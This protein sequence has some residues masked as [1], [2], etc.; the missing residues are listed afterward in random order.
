MTEFLDLSDVMGMMSRTGL[1]PVRD[2]GLL[3]SAVMRPRSSAFG[4]DAYP[5]LATK[6]AALMHSI[7][8]NHALV[9]GNR[10]LALLATMTFLYLN[11][12]DSTSGQ[13]EAVELVLGVAT[14]LFDVAEIATALRIVATARPDNAS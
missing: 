4:Q 3:D 6:A 2:I 14:G 13:K 1:G 8:R 10:R 5:D 12:Y 11:G 7:A 9:D